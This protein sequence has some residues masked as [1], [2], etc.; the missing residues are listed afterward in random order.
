MSAEKSF[1]EFVRLQVRDVFQVS[2]PEDIDAIGDLAQRLFDVV[3]PRP[4]EFDAS[5]TARER[6]RCALRVMIPIIGLAATRRYDLDW[7]WEALFDLYGGLGEV[8]RGLKPPVFQPGPRSAKAARE[9]DYDLLV[10]SISAMAWKKLVGFG[11][12]SEEAAEQVAGCLTNHRFLKNKLRNNK[13]IGCASTRSIKNWAK[14]LDGREGS[15]AIDAPRKG[16]LPYSPDLAESAY[17]RG[18]STPAQVLS[19]LVENLEA[20]RGSYFKGLSMVMGTDPP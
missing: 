12:G 9:S 14:R 16:Y 7:V 4:L 17:F 1:T 10:K 15:R 18:A 11:I 5:W 13:A 8:E 2:S 3:L 19:R 20:L 6:L